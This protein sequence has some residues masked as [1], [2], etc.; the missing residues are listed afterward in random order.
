ML[1]YGINSVK[2]AV[3]TYSKGELFIIAGKNNPRITEIESLAV[4][5][6]MK[7][8]SL[9]KDDFNLKF[10]DDDTQGI[11]FETQSTPNFEMNE[12]I[13]YEKIGKS[14]GCETI[15]ILDCIKDIGNLGSILRTAL[16]FGVQYVVIPKNNSA[17][18]N[19][20]VIKRSAGAVFSLN[21]V[22]VTNI[23][24]VIERLKKNEFWIYG[25][26][27][28]GFSI[29]NF[30]YA[31]KTAIVMGDEGE[32]IR[33]LVKENCDQLIKIPTTD[34][35]DSLNVGVSAGVIL[36]DRFIKL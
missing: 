7:I 1:V 9:N 10:K 21:I 13:F 25:A 33:R 12:N 19:D 17:A 27:M 8:N 30:T 29:K 18:V 2:E 22:Y 28:S 6:N 36:Y 11:V 23:N 32:G 24:R 3:K 16:L 15:L 26:D 5:K 34:K 14:Q 35:L 20:V 4:S 31:E